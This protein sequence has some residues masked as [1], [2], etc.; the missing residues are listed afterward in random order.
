[1]RTSKLSNTLLFPHQKKSQV[2]IFLFFF[3]LLKKCL[4]LYLLSIIVLA[5][6]C[7]TEKEKRIEM[8]A[9]SHIGF[10]LI[11]VLYLYFSYFLLLSLPSHISIPH[12]VL[13]NGGGV[14]GKLIYRYEF[15]TAK[16]SPTITH[17][18]EFNT[19]NG[20]FRCLAYDTH[21]FLHPLRMLL[22]FFFS[23]L[24]FH[25]MLLFSLFIREWKCFR[26]T[27]GNH[28]WHIA[29]LCSDHWL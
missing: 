9:I 4:F 1:M 24:S 10:S 25:F 13:I 20:Q 22:Q 18:M 3:R 29:K 27:E 16:C 14:W 7:L 8:Q 21:S 2:W 28:M 11:I 15:H 5:L 17:H 26:N 12:S 6:C 19:C 23:P